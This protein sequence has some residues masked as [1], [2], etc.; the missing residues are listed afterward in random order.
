MIVWIPVPILTL[1]LRYSLILSEM[2]IFSLAVPP[3]YVFSSSSFYLN[4]VSVS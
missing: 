4:D 3:L 2:K 1:T